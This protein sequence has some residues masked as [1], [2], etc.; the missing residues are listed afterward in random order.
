MNSEAEESL[1]LLDLILNKEELVNKGTHFDPNGIPS[2]GNNQS[3]SHSPGWDSD[4]TDCMEL[5]QPLNSSTPAISS[6]QPHSFRKPLHPRFNDKNYHK[7]ERLTNWWKQNRNNMGLS[8]MVNIYHKCHEEQ[9]QEKGNIINPEE[10]FYLC[11]ESG[12]IHECGG[13]ERCP[14]ILTTHIGTCV[15]II[16]ALE[17][18]VVYQNDFLQNDYSNYGK[19]GESN[20]ANKYFSEGAWGR[21]LH[22]INEKKKREEFL[23]SPNNRKKP[24]GH[25][26]VKI[27][28][29]KGEREKKLRDK[30]FKKDPF[31]FYNSSSPYFVPRSVVNEIV[32]EIMTAFNSLFFDEEVR[33]KVREENVSNFHRAWRNTTNSYFKECYQ[34]GTKVSVMDL[35]KLFSECEV[36][37]HIPEMCTMDQREV[38]FLKD[39]IVKTWELLRCYKVIE[40][41]SS[42]QF[43]EK[44]IYAL[45]YIM[46][47]SDS[48]GL[49]WLKTWL[50]ESTELKKYS[51]SKKKAINFIRE[52]KKMFMKKE[53]RERFKRD[54]VLRVESEI[55]EKHD[56]NYP[57]TWLFL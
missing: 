27:V 54:D 44:F 17:V 26:S 38:L 16:S 6:R 39:I 28:R 31:G 42:V 43:K 8:D 32:K 37:N 23:L 48:E 57:L 50:P 34:S 52:I 49:T 51:N 10:N 45:L 47:D 11:T 19:V 7:K 35:D 21:M 9:C 2:Q 55:M 24:R 53:H 29:P 12:L 33:K 5:V 20:S 36:K 25:P 41:K 56:R 22:N 46:K 40:D 14:E 13:S 30:D 18:G 4:E 1:L 15:C 3:Y